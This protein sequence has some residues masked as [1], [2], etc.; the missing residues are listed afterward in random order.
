MP[1]FDV[2]QIT[3]AAPEIFMALATIA[4][5]MLG[6]FRGDGYTRA[7]SWFAVLVLTLTAALVMTT[8]NE[9][10]LS[11]F[12][13]L[14][15]VDS[16]AAFMKPLVLLGAALAIIMSIDYIEREKFARAE[17]PII[18]LFAT[19]GMLLMISANDLIALYLGLELQSLA[20][21]VAAAIRRDAVRSTEA[22]L[23]YF[24]LGA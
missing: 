17:Y 4:L 21:Y 19:L 11:G 22:G 15:I 24:V 8:G 13:G 14:F 23:K 6:V 12:G 20:L 10:P 18:I 3:P 9:Q 1:N 16:F 7:L 5:L 2:T